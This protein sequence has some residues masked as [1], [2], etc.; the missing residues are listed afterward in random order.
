MIKKNEI[1][2]TCN[3]GKMISIGN[4]RL[5]CNKCN[6]IAIQIDKSEFYENQKIGNKYLLSE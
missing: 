6:E 2:P 1:C 4:N 3:I 5:K